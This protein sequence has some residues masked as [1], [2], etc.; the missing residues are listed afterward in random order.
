MKETLWRSRKRA[1]ERGVGPQQGLKLCG[2]WTSVAWDRRTKAG[3]WGSK[4]KRNPLKGFYAGA[5]A[6]MTIL[7]FQTDRSGHSKETIWAVEA[8]RSNAHRV[9]LGVRTTQ[10]RHPVGWVRSRHQ[11]LIWPRPSA[12]PGYSLCNARPPPTISAPRGQRSASD[13]VVSQ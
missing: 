6:D 7:E 4:G 10:E 12:L 8:S 5:G 9:A 11:L 3:P 2:R 13:V 1:W